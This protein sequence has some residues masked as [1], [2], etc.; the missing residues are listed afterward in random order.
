MLGIVHSSRQKK[1][2]LFFFCLVLL[3]PLV[4]HHQPHEHTNLAPLIH[5]TSNIWYLP[6]R[7]GGGGWGRGGDS[8]N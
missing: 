5:Y 8:H 3:V 7:V 1:P 2:L 4:S 6:E